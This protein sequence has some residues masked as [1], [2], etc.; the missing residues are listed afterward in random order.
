MNKKVIIGMI[1]S[2]MTT[3]VFA[4]SGFYAGFSLGSVDNKTSVS[5]FENGVKDEDESLSGSTT[6]YAIKGGY[7]FSQNFAV[8][9]AHQEYG[10]K[11][12][13]EVDEFDTTY[14]DKIDTHSTNIGV[15]GMIPLSDSFS[16]NATLGYAF[17]NFKT[18][19][20]DSDF[21][22]E[23]NGFSKSDKDLYYSIGGEYAVNESI[24]LGLEYSTLTMNWGYSFD[25]F[26]VDIDHEVNNIAFTV[27]VKF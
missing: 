27:Q 10:A 18:T 12:H 7:Q 20:T 3:P 19:S 6:S 2:A 15:K 22:G 14:T 23:V 25:E 8:E 1:L 21:P 24:S 26:S 9:L 11:T 17:W 5:S 16:L 4:D 13:T